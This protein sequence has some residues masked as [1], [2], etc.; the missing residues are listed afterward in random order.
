[1]PRRKP[2]NL[3]KPGESGNPAGRPV[4]SLSEINA[5]VKQAFAMLLHSQL[6]NMEKWLAEGAKRDPLKTADLML[7]ISERFTPSLSR[8]E[9][10]GRDGEAFTPITIN[11][12]TFHL[13]KPDTT[14][15]IGEGTSTGSL[16]SPLS[17]GIPSEGTSAETSIS[18][19]PGNVNPGEG[20]PT[21]TQPGHYEHSHSAV[22]KEDGHYGHSDSAVSGED[23][24]DLPDSP[25]FVFLPADLVK[26]PPPGYRREF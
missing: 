7:R 6:P 18:P 23:S 14:I 16:S 11:I 1:M 19:V 8:Q 13:P 21:E 22:S 2:K 25:E 5:Q 17:L 15:E 9:I 24:Q 12:P 20:A 3:W 4:G 10:T 26:A